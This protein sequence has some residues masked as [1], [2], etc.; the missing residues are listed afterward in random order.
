VKFVA[1]AW[2]ALGQGLKA[3]SMTFNGW[4][5]SSIFRMSGLPYERDYTRLVG[6]G[7]GSTIVMACVQWICRTFPEAPPAIWK[8]DPDGV[9]IRVPKHPLVRLLRFPTSA[10]GLPGG[11]YSGV[12]LWMATLASWIIDGNAYWLKVRSEL[13]RVVQVWYVP[14]W[15]LEPKWPTD[16]SAFISHYD[17]KVNGQIFK[18][19]PSEVV[20]FRH[21]LDP[22]N[23]RKGKSPLS[24]ALREVYTDEEAARFSASILKNLG[25]P[26]VVVSPANAASGVWRASDSDVQMVKEKFNQDFG[27]DRRG[28]PLVMSTPTNVEQFGFSPDQLNLEHLRHLPE[29]RVSALL[30]L[31]AAVIGFGAGLRNTKV[32]ATMA[33]LRDQAWQSNLIPTQ[34]IMGEEIATQLLSDF[35]SDLEAYEFGFDTSRVKVLQEDQG[36]QADRWARLVSSGIAKRKEARVA[37]DLP[38]GPEDDVYLPQP[39]VTGDAGPEPADSQ[40]SSD[41]VAQLQ[42]RVAE[43]EAE[44]QAAS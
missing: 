25:I 5:T 28:E 12:H 32:G 4:A 20:H 35:T 34:R 44:L 38:V 24:T 37:F 19:A 31:P 17:Y 16:G 22:D 33:E 10:P 26:G 7:S 8:M 2:A 40:A 14:H 27:A 1:R 13:G 39:G 15:M 6:D 23:T 41:Q 29:E 42:A 11:H 9:R 36:K 18:I 30:G 21:G 3:A 43:L